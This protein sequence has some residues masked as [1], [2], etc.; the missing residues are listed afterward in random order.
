MIDL[1]G[2]IRAAAG[3]VSGSK[4]GASERPPHARQRRVLDTHHKTMSNLKYGHPHIRNCYDY[5]ACDT[6]PPSPS[7]PRTAKQG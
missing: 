4:G 7:H 5:H 1:L 2:F 6:K 3:A